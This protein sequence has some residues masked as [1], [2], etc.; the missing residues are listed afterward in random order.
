MFEA[1]KCSAKLLLS[2]KASKKTGKENCLK[3]EIKAHF[4]Q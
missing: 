1:Y 3:N 4:Y 2:E